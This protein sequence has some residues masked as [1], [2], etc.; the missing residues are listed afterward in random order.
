MVFHTM[1]DCFANEF[2]SNKPAICNDAINHQRVWLHTKSTLINLYIYIL[3]NIY[4]YVHICLSKSPVATG[5]F[6]SFFMGWFRTRQPFRISV[7]VVVA[8][9]YYF[10]CAIFFIRSS[11]LHVFFELP[12]TTCVA[13]PR[14]RKHQRDTK[15][16]YS[17]I[18][19]W[20][21]IYTIRT[22]YGI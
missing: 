15:K 16:T 2:H 8:I 20:W 13:V 11:I 18:H 17:S 3:M 19:T 21:Y 22:L 14:D 1:N 9:F 10:I 6:R 4:I 7:V 5:G 12:P